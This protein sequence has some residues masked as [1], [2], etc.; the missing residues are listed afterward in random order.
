MAELKTLV[1][2]KCGAEV[3]LE[4]A[5]DRGACRYCGTLAYVENP[6]RQQPAKQR[7]AARVTQPGLKLALA[8]SGM[9]VLA[10]AGTLL[11]LLTQ[12][13]QAVA[14]RP[15]PKPLSEIFRARPG[16]SAAPVAPPSEPVFHVQSH[17][18]ARLVDSDGDKRD[19]L[20]LP[21]EQTLDHQTTSHF[22][23]F[24][25]TDGKLLRQTPPIES[26]GS[27]LLSAVAYGR[28]VLALPNGQLT[29]YDLAS[30]D[31]QWSTALGERVAAL[32]QVD[33]K[34]SDSLHIVTDDGRNLLVDVKT[35]RQ[36]VTRSACKIPLAVS[37]GRHAPADRRDYRAPAE[38]EAWLCGGVRVMGS[39]NYTVPDAC[40]QHTQV[41]ADRLDGI[42][43][44]AMWRV[45]RDYL[46]LGVRK[47]GSYVPMVGLLSHKRWLWKSEVP[48]SN[49][50]A[51]ESGGPRMLSLLNERLTLGYSSN[52]P[53]A[54]WL[55]SF[56]VRDGTRRWSQALPLSSGGLVA[57][58]QDERVLVVHT[59]HEARLLAPDTGSLIATI[60]ATE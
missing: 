9:L 13:P 18:P 31:S 5:R 22:A 40:R 15:S 23:I 44:H 21:V 1:C 8:V 32:C 30:G 45:G 10:G 53:R 2:P 26:A 60:G 36:S 59:E 48:A 14:P 58:A 24:S 47:P 25:T 35:G 42:I 33:P 3:Q 29:G 28:L 55:T 27:S 17:T 39:D 51:A 34:T 16:A 6:R 41:D 11:A 57:L 46:V 20:L 43:G 19:E 38:T 4:P 54:Q 12:T 52:E 7:A 56:D 50:L 49:P 37:M